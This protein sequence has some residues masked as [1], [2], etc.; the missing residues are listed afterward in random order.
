MCGYNAEFL[1]DHACSNV[2]KT[3]F[4]WLHNVGRMY[5]SSISY[6]SESTI[7]FICETRLSL[8]LIKRQAMK[9]APRFVNLGTRRRWAVSFRPPLLYPR[10][11]LFTLDGWLDG[12]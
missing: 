9:E 7:K 11:A 8:C 10:E 4:H 6:I 12:L 5:R 2:A 1:N 3:I